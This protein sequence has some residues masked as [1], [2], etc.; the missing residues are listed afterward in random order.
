MEE[1]K[2]YLE[3]DGVLGVVRS[4]KG[5]VR[6]FRHRGVFDLF[7]L[8]S[9]NPGFMKGGTIADKV[10]GRGAALLIAKGEIAQVYARLISLPAIEVLE[11]NGIPVTFDKQVPHIINR[12]GTDICPVEKLTS[13]ISDP[14]EAFSLIADFVQRM[15]KG[16]F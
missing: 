11:K 6:F 8:L 10:I 16:N 7:K 2:K 12:E 1:L 14:E 5:D 3:Q 9:A 4:S 15:N 13:H